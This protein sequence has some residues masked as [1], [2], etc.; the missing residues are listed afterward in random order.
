MVRVHTYT[1]S[2]PDGGEFDPI[3]MC[4][5]RYNP[6]EAPLKPMPKRQ[7]SW[8]SF[9]G[10]REAYQQWLEDPKNL[11]STSM[12]CSQKLRLSSKC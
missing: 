5:C 6:I 8:E 12:S 9:G 2:T 10:D 1:L 7:V 3:A 11:R 4:Y